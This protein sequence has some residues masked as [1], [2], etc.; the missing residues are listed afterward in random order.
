MCV[1][2]V[3]VL[4]VVCVHYVCVVC[5]CYVCCVMYVCYVCIMCVYMC[6]CMCV[7][8]MCVCVP[9][10]IHI[11]EGFSHMQSY[12]ASLE[13]L[14][15]GYHHVPHFTNKETEAQSVFFMKH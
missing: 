10:Y 6:V 7:C 9:K 1:C 4:C 15:D 12:L 13:T 3:C 5:A 14:R 8:V 11:C 2:Y